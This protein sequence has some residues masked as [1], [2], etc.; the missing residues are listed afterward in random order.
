MNPTV[1]LADD[2]ALVRIAFRTIFEAHG[3][4]VVG[5]ATD[6]DEAIT[7]TLRQR[8]DVVLM[9]V[10]MPRR[11]GLSAIDELRTRSPLTRIVVLTTFDDDAYLDAALRAG[12][13]GFLL[14][15]AS[16]EELVFAVRRVAA[17][18]AVLD[19]GVT[20]R[21]LA[22]V[23]PKTVPPD[24]HPALSS[25]TDRERAVFVLLAEGLTNA[26]IAARLHVGEATVKTHISRV[27][28][29]LNLRD[30]IQAVIFAYQQ[31]VARS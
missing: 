13:N 28:A 3:I 17:G 16:P 27:L 30:R 7:V 1:V 19:P 15:N 8:P 2:H 23:A 11:D 25:L 31:G 18:D 6:G 5:E 4:Q 9:D 10:R 26:E 24:Q 21:V 22:R 12:A 20:A 29:K 14:K